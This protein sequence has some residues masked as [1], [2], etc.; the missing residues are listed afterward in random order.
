MKEIMAIHK[1]IS[2]C[3]AFSILFSILPMNSLAEESDFSGGEFSQVRLNSDLSN[4]IV[5]IGSKTYSTTTDL[6]GN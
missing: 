4:T 3:L 2:T 5:T 1:I 6:N